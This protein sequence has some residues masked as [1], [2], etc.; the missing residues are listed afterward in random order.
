MESI[1]FRFNFQIVVKD[2]QQLF[3]ES[4]VWPAIQMG[5]L[6]ERRYLLGTSL[7]R[8]CITLGLIAL[9]FSTTFFKH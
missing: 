9:K 7:A 8:P 1:L 2:L 3:V 6:Y 4:F 5:L